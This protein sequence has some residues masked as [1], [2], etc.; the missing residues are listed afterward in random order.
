MSSAISAL[1]LDDKSLPVWL[2]ADMQPALVA[3][4]FRY[5]IRQGSLVIDD[6]M[7]SQINI[8]SVDQLKDG[9]TTVNYEV[10]SYIGG[11]NGQDLMGLLPSASFFPRVD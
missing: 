9:R 7:A 4:G 6:L 11:A 10:V 2:S 3:G 1:P 5:D 8:P